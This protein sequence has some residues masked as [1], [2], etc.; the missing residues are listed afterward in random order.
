MEETEQIKEYRLRFDK[1][2]EIILSTN[3]RIISGSE[4]L[5]CDNVNFYTKTY[6][7]MQCVYLESYI[8]EVA[9]DYFERGLITQKVYNALLNYKIEITD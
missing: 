5:F 1:L 3:E 8:K 7:I 4:S 2:I 9:Q 6:L